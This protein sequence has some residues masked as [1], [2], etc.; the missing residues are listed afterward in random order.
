MQICYF[1][2][3]FCQDI[4]TTFHISHCCCMND[5]L[6][7]NNK[8]PV[9]RQPLFSMHLPLSQHCPRQLQNH[10]FVW[11]GIQLQ[12]TESSGLPEASVSLTLSIFTLLQERIRFPN[13]LL[14]SFSNCSPSMAAR[15]LGRK[16]GL[17]I[18]II[19]T[20]QSSCVRAD[21]RL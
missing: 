11:V 14:L 8:L 4:C 5:C 12:T 1:K 18:T 17:Q 15:T 19:N 16:K 10:F 21:K 7:Y 2:S 13:Y 9:T 6:P 3:Q 20:E